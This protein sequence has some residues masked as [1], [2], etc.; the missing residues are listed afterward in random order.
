MELDLAM[1][2]SS[3]N[4]LQLDQSLRVRIAEALVPTSK[5]KVINSPFEMIQRVHGLFQDTLYI[6]L[7]ARGQVITLVRPKKHSI[8]P[9]G[10][11]RNFNLSSDPHFILPRC[12]STHSHQYCLLAVYC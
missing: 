8:H 2:T 4:C 7:I 10:T 6:I 1:A 5:M 3:L 11:C 9:A 12:R